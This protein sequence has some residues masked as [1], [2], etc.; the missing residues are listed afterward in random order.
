MNYLAHA[1]LSFGK[2]EIIIGNLI[3]DFI[4]GKEKLSFSKEIQKGIEIH[5][6]IDRFT[7]IHPV[8]KEAKQL[9][10]PSAKRYA[11]AF[12]DIVYDHFLASDTSTF[13][14]PEL[15]DFTQRIYSIL[16]QSKAIL[17]EKFLYMYGYMQKGNW[18]YNYHQKEEM[19]RAFIGMSRR[20]IYLTEKDGEAIYQD[21]LRNYEPLQK[22]YQDFMPDIIRYIQEEE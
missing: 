6:R 9:L 7:D 15:D 18:L 5:Y 17:P 4:V 22:A 12:M 13:T 10:S 1:Y 11:G 21:F 3:T 16:D 14:L 2:K 19:H 20:A 8:T